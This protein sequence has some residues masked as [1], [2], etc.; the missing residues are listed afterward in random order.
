MV[1][2]MIYCI[3]DRFA[4]HHEK[5]K[6]IDEARELAKEEEKYGTNIKSNQEMHTSNNRMK[7]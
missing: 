5:R 1:P 4:F 2:Y 6:E 3:R 7:K